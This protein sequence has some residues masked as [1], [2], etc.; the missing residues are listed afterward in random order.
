M[1]K[2][3]MQEAD[4]YIARRHRRR[5]WQKIVGSLACVV[6]FCTTYALILPA[7]TMEKYNCGLTEHTHTEECYAKVTDSDERE[8]I[9]TLESLDIHKHDE[10][11]RDKDG[12]LICGY[13]DFVVH[14]H[15]EDCYDREGNLW[16]PLPEIK[17]HT[18]NK[19]CYEPS[20]EAHIH[21]A[22]CYTVE[23]G[24]LICT[25]SGEN[26]THDGGCY[27][28][29]QELICTAE[30]SA[31]HQHSSDCYTASRVNICGQEEW[32]GHTHGEGCYDENGDLVCGQEES[33]GHVHTDDCYQENQELSCG[34]EESAGHTHGSECY[35]TGQRLICGMEENTHEHTADCYEQKKVLNCESSAGQEEDGDVQE[36]LICNREEIILHEHDETCFD[37]EKN[38]I[39]DKVQVLRHVH[40]ADC[41]R[42][43]E[44]E[45]GTEIETDAAEGELI[46]TLEEHTHT[47]ECTKPEALPAGSNDV[48]IR[49]VVIEEDTA[50]E[51]GQLAGKFKM[52]ENG[53]VPLADSTGE[54]KNYLTSAGILINGE[55]YD[56]T[57][58]LNPGGEFSVELRWELQRADLEKSKTWTYT[59]PPQLHVENVGK[60]ILTD[61]SGN[62]KGE[63]SIQDGVLTVTYDNVSD[64]TNTIFELN[65]TWNQ[66]VIDKETEVKWNDDLKTEVKFGNAKIAVTKK[67]SETVNKKDGSLIGIYQIGIT[68]ENAAGRV[69]GIT[70]TDTLTAEKF[71]FCREYYKE[72]GQN[73]D[74]R[75]TVD[76]GQTYTYGNFTSTSGE[77]GEKKFTISDISLE[78]N[79]KYVLEYG[80]VLDADKRLELDSKQETAGLRNNALASYE[81]NGENITSSVTV[82]DVYRTQ[83]KWLVKEK[84]NEQ[85]ADPK[86]D[87]PWSITVNMDR[88][89]D[90]GGAVI[91][92]Q[93]GTAEAFYKTSQAVNAIMVTDQGRTEKELQWITLSNN[94]ISII[95]N[96]K[97]A[98]EFLF[99]NEGAAI[100][101][102]IN[103]AV[104]HTVSREEISNYVFVNA[105][106][107]QFAWFTPENDIPTTYRLNYVTDISQ[108][109]SG[110]ITNS[111]NA[112]WKDYVV[113]DTVG[114][115]YREVQLTKEN[116]GV[117]EKEGEEGYY[118]DWNI[119]IRVPENCSRIENVC[120][121]D[122]LPRYYDFDYNGQKIS[123]SD[124]LMGLGNSIDYAAYS[125][126]PRGYLDSVAK[127]AFHIS[128]GCTDPTI[129]AYVKGLS[130]TLGNPASANGA[131]EHVIYGSD[132]TDLGQLEV[133]NG[134]NDP[135]YANKRITPYTFGVDLH[136]IPAAAD[137][138]SYTINVAYTTRVNPAMLES[139][140]GQ[141]SGTNYA[142]VRQ[143][144]T[145]FPNLILAKADST[146]WVSHIKGNKSLK[147][148]VAT[149]DPEN[150]I[151]TYEVLINPDGALD[152]KSCDYILSDVL[153][154]T[155]G[156]FVDGSFR[157]SLLG[158]FDKDYN[159]VLDP[160][161]ETELWP[162][163]GDTLITSYYQTR[164]GLEV[165]NTD[166]G[167]SEFTLT[168][169][170]GNDYGYYWQKDGKMLPMK[171]TYQVSLPDSFSSGVGTQDTITNSITLT[172]APKDS[173]P[174][175]V[176]GDKTDFNYTTALRKRL[177]VSP[178][179]NNGYTAG[180]EILVDKTVKEWPETD[181]FTVIDTL[182]KSL[183]ADI[184]SVQVY[185][186]RRGGGETLLTSGYTV[187][188]D[189]RPEEHNLLSI[190]V[191]ESENAEEYVGYRMTYS[192]RVL[193]SVGDRVQFDNVAAIE[194][195]SIQ[196]EKVEEEV[197]IQKQSGA[198]EEKHYEVKLLKYDASNATKRLSA[199]FALYAYENGSWVLRVSDLVTDEN[200]E[201]SINNTDYPAANLGED[202]WFKLVETAAPSGYL[203]G[204]VTYFHIGMTD[205]K[206]PDKT[207]YTV[208]PVTGGTLS[209]PNYKMELRL[210]K[211]SEGKNPVSLSG[212]EFAL[213]LDEKCIKQ[214][215]VSTEHSGGI[216]RFDLQNGNLTAGT[217]YYLKETKA[218]AGYHLSDTVYTVTFDIK[219]KVT[220]KSGETELTAEKT[221]AFPITNR[222]SHELPHTG[223]F[224]TSPYIAG[225]V[226]AMLWAGLFLLYKEKKYRKGE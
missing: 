108:V 133:I 110:T 153:D 128:T 211:V 219:G 23:Q 218:P 181:K 1:Q 124:W 7:I 22:S 103:Q 210:H 89:Y 12:K 25:Q 225:G 77:N 220:L 208:I 221:G 207:S 28:E 8:P 69:D 116:S 51:N 137:G 83:T 85:V 59:L 120:L 146:Y 40:L 186:I 84:G 87:M 107:D 88:N 140:D 176:D 32:E 162:N 139:L 132:Q 179:E 61:N 136:T 94:T 47:E 106:Q 180:F 165:A 172:A 75:Y 26:H 135:N 166:A 10:K 90:M 5:I 216:Y 97:N 37:K 68:A 55:P 149:F 41:F 86:S 33:A 199:T 204:S 168:I 189:D 160:A 2:N 202:T 155:D 173:V 145:E 196:S 126:D 157:L 117:Y 113:G 29:Y 217:D 4:K 36:K 60:T 79:Q 148:S 147:K 203:S 112:G 115:F 14:E 190:T 3:R 154:V 31:G 156:H 175:I 73:Y 78:K 101:S 92:D 206:N 65:A 182:S 150:D 141:T 48:V 44:T 102:E 100:L 30:E 21:D 9:C 58:E 63:Y 34:M 19:E 198:V 57:S 197:Y 121:Y 164:V 214:I 125:Q 209:I 64:G 27:E 123:G 161:V 163:A 212:A 185:G 213:Y 195:T 99:S 95:K 81:A 35:E 6:V 143:R 93:I 122:T 52:Q 49:A 11:C 134:D 170:P 142:E 104:G 127:N 114:S 13:A 171:L 111:A 130:G 74:Y 174:V 226:L 70:L 183:A 194:G 205:E 71:E 105:S 66:E 96:T 187:G 18:H 177:T 192:T 17:E 184:T 131:F 82:E 188:Y 46:C 72:N 24:D 91:S 200:G 50:G 15:N 119:H 53:I 118:V 43:A 167:S 215:A 129:Q 76:G 223:G 67:N 16:C 144:T 109:S 45:T 222:F 138:Q 224:G 98:I 56:G 178:A 152:Y 158:E 39:C 193:G 159:I 20:G 62:R 169:R 191:S 201:L 42:T 38:L 54:I 151:L 80:V